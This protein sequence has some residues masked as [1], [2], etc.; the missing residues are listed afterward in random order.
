MRELTNE[1]IKRV[2]TDYGM[3]VGRTAVV[4]NL[5]QLRLV[6]EWA[7][8]EARAET[9]RETLIEEQKRTYAKAAGD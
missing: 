2:A 9:I 1:L 5:D 8:M 3:D 4:G 7:R 6:M